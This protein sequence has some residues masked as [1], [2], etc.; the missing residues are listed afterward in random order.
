MLLHSEGVPP[1]LGLYE[2]TYLTLHCLSTKRESM[3]ETRTVATKDFH[4]GSADQKDR[5]GSKLEASNQE[6]NNLHVAIGLI[7]TL[8]LES[9]SSKEPGRW[10]EWVTRAS[11]GLVNVPSMAPWTIA[12]IGYQQYVKK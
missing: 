5:E 2:G 10:L 11:F 8:G 3:V 7:T 9:I 1:A 4:M 6:G 12:Q